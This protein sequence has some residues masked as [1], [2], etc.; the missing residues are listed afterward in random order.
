[1]SSVSHPKHYNAGKIEL[2]EAIEDWKLCYH[3][4]NAL[5]YIARAGKKDASKYAEDLE[6]ARWYLQRAIEITKESPRRPNDMNPRVGVDMGSGDQTTIVEF[7][8]A[9]VVE[10]VKIL[11][12][13]GFCGAVEGTTHLVSCLTQAKP[14]PVEEQVTNIPCP[15]C[16]A[17]FDE[18]HHV[19]C[20]TRT[21]RKGKRPRRTCTGC[22]AVFYSDDQKPLCGSCSQ[23]HSNS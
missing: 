4:G 23:P 22:S 14:A 20:V 11:Q 21:L 13:C 7:K 15:Y 2:I 9:P 6:K 1:M 10:A 12:T 19:S 8:T 18:L 5:K 17:K 16:F 3:L